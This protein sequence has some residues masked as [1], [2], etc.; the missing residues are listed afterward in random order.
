MLLYFIVKA[1]RKD[2]MYW[3]PIYGC[4][5]VFMSFMFRLLIKVSVDWTSCVQF[6]HP[7]ELGGLMWS[8]SR[9]CTLCM[10]VFSL[11]EAV[12]PGV[13]ACEERTA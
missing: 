9:A 7:Q 10:G 6:R 3:A 8:A 11:Y 5:G 1:A 4:R 12:S 2:F 13:R